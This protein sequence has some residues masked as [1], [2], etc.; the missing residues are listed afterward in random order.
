M[1]TGSSDRRRREAKGDQ[2]LA[3]AGRGHDHPLHHDG[4]RTV[5]EA[6]CRKER[7]VPK[8]GGGVEDAPASIDDLGPVGALR[9][10]GFGGVAQSGVGLKDERA[11]VP[12]PRAQALARVTPL[13]PLDVGGRAGVAS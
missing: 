2:R 12:G 7:A 9:T 8:S 4:V 10:P 5:R 11:D 6:R 1:I 13:E 3:P